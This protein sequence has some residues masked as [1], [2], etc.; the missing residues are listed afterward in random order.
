MDG[1]VS[2]DCHPGDSAAG[3]LAVPWLPLPGRNE[4][5]KVGGV[6]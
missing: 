3:R 6:S 1:I 5:A 4:S 2:Q